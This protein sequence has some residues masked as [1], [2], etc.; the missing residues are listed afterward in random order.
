MI[1]KDTRRAAYPMNW[2]PPA[3]AVTQVIFRYAWVGLVLI[4]VAG[5][6]LFGLVF[7]LFNSALARKTI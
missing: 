7:L 2:I 4:A 5:S 3:K 1:W 6:R